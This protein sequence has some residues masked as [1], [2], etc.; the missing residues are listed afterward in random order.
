MFVYKEPTDKPVMNIEEDGHLEKDS[1]VTGDRMSTFM[2]YL[3][4]VF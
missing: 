4:E 2:V 1:Y 3:T